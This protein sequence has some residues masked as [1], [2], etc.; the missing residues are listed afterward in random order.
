MI[1]KRLPTL[2]KG[3]VGLPP[4]SFAQSPPSWPLDAP[5]SNVQHEATLG[6]LPYAINYMVQSTT[7]LIVD[8]D[9]MGNLVAIDHKKQLI[10]YLT[11]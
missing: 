7:M 5:S 1:K 6:Q 10:V 11:I 3:W 8:I 9:Q 2:C 4:M